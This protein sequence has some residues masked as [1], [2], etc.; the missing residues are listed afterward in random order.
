MSSWESDKL[1]TQ[2]VPKG[3]LRRRKIWR[4]GGTRKVAG[5]RFNIIFIAKID[6][7]IMNSGAG[8]WESGNGEINN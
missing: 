2:H 3:L 7:K 8:T 5:L 6:R 4:R 1:G